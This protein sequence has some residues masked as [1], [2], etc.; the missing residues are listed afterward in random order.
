MQA[1]AQTLVSNTGQTTH[2]YTACV[3]GSDP[4]L[5]DCAQGFT[6][7]QNTRGYDLS[8]IQL[9]TQTAPGSGTLTVTVRATGS[10]QPSNAVLYTLTNPS[11]VGTGLQTF[12]APGG[13]GL[14]RNT[15]YF[16]HMT[17]SGSGTRP[18]WYLTANDNED[19][20]MARGWSIGNHRYTRRSDGTGGWEGDGGVYSTSIQIR[21]K[22]NTLAPAAPNL[23]AAPGETEVMLTW[24][25][26]GN[27]TITRYQYRR[28]TGAGAYGNWIDIGG[29]NASTDSYTVTGLTSSTAYTFGVRA[30]NVGGNGAAATVTT[31]TLPAA[32][33]NL[34][35]V[36][37]DG[38][39]KL[40]WTD[41]DSDAITK[42]QYRRKTDTGTY[43]NWTDIPNSDKYTTTYTVTDLSNGTRYRFGVRALVNVSDPGPASTVAATPLA[44]PAAP[45]LLA[46]AGNGQVALSWT[47]PGNNT[48]TKYQYRR[49][50]GTGT[51]GNWTDIGGSSWTTTT[52]T[53]TGLS[54]G[55]QY[56]MAVRA[57][58]ASGEGAVST[59]NA[60]PVWAAP[61]NLSA[62]PGSGQVTLT[63]TGP[64][65][66]TITKYQVSTDDGTTFTDIDINGSSAATINHAVTGLTNGTTYPL[67]LR[68]ANASAHGAAATVTATPLWPA[69][70]LLAEPGDEKVVLTWNTD[71]GVD[72]YQ[73][74]SQ[75]TSGGA[76]P[77][78]S[79]GGRIRDE[80]HHHHC[81]PDQRHRIHLHGAGGGSV[82]QQRR[83][84]R[85]ASQRERDAGAGA[86]RTD[87]PLGHAG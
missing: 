23:S 2:G 57:V 68:A 42:Y 79:Y 75:V 50:T 44:R 43:G 74:H 35:P 8:S 24:D 61:A 84:H 87:E 16:V 33:T 64:G 45:N 11:N 21:V 81:R 71:S 78:I 70:G 25:D 49:K 30:K 47:N 51:Y 63:W 13:A 15:Q 38:E 76:T 52:Y 66:S 83:D 29:S 56:T 65:D 18:R 72:E 69:P 12:T 7:G 77:D 27:N 10:G 14:N 48:I 73:I 60:T 34:W 62:T 85:P 58:N 26:P 37:G 40:S 67:A 39:V 86:G 3:S 31:A 59:V 20:G 6:T 36:P 28:K 54:N 9:D 19:S 53:V 1:H 32:P 4:D 46:T 80:D 17:F 82:R 41:P 5:L 55:T 22:G